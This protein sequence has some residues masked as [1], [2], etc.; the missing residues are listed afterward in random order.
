MPSPKKRKIRKAIGNIHPG[1]VLADAQ[2][3]DT[4]VEVLLSENAHNYAAA[5]GGKSFNNGDVVGLSAAD[6]GDELLAAGEQDSTTAMPAF[7]TVSFSGINSPGLVIALTSSAGDAVIYTTTNGATDAASNLFKGNADAATCAAQLKVCIDDA[8]GH[9]GAIK[10]LD[11]G[12][13]TL[14]LYQNVEGSA[15]NTLIHHDLDAVLA[16][17]NTFSGGTDSI[18]V[19]GS[20]AHYW[21]DTTNAKSSVAAAAAAGVAITASSGIIYDPSGPNSKYISGCETVSS[22]T[23]MYM[24]FRPETWDSA[25]DSC[26]IEIVGNT[27][28]DGSGDQLSLMTINANADTAVAATAIN[29]AGVADNFTD[30]DGDMDHNSNHNRTSGK[31]GGFVIKWVRGSTGLAESD[32]KKG[33]Y[34]RWNSTND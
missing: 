25:G 23:A 12:A 3:T 2:K 22:G 29:S 14:T 32:I 24:V 28:T 9:N 26:N 5:P 16:V 30:V 7:A 10:A 1:G 31:E 4:F 15:G 6:S 20:V 13:G 27:N 8:A 33:W 18:A 21:F 17:S 19:T 34:V 11:D